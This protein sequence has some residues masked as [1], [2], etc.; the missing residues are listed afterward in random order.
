M[1]SFSDACYLFGRLFSSKLASYCLNEFNYCFHKVQKWIISSKRQ[2][3]ELDMHLKSW[4]RLEQ[5]IALLGIDVKIS[6]HCPSPT[7]I[8][9]VNKLLSNLYDFYQIHI[10]IFKFTFLKKA[11]PLSEVWWYWSWGIRLICFYNWTARAIWNSLLFTSHWEKS[12]VEMQVV[13]NG[14][15]HRNRGTER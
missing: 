4:V 8:L 11:D 3:W 9:S 10:N 12:S 6:C 2:D 1:N 14:S 7:Q 13:L 15:E 5:Q